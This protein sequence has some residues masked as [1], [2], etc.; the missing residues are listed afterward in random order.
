[1]TTRETNLGAA[2][3]IVQALL[4]FTD[5]AV[6]NRPGFIVPDTSS[7]LGV[8]WSAASHRM[9]GPEK[10]DFVVY[11]DRKGKGKSKGRRTRLG[12]K[13]PNSD[14][15]LENGREVGRYRPAGL[16]PEAA[17]WIYQQIANIWSCDNEFAARWASFAFGE[18]H[19]DLK[20]ALAAFMLVQ[21]RSGMPVTEGGEFLFND[22]DYR[23]VGEAMLLIRRGD[24]KGFNPKLILR[25]RELLKLPGVAAI[26]RGLGF[27]RSL[28]NEPVGR[29]SRTVYKWLSH[30]EQ[31]PRLLSK[32]VNN[33]FKGS[34]RK[35]AKR[36]GYKP[37]SA[38]FFEA[39]GWKQEQAEDGR[40]TIAIGQEI[41]GAES[42]EGLSEVEVCKRITRT[43]PNWKR[44]VGLLNR[45]TITPAMV[46]AG[47][48]AGA[49]SSKDML[50]MTGT[51]EELGL[52]D[53]QEVRAKWERATQ[54]ATDL[55]ARNVAQKV[56]SKEIKEKLEDAADNALKKSIADVVRGMRVYVL[57][58]IS[59][60]MN[61]GI[62]V[63][64]T[65]LA[66]MLQ[67]F[68]L[69]K[70]HV[71]VFNNSGRVVTI[72]HASAKGV[73]KAFEGIRATGGTTHAAGVRALRDFKPKA[74]ED[75]LF[76]VVGDEGEDGN[77]AAE[78][79]ASGLRPM[80]FGLVKLKT[81]DSGKTA[82]TATARELGIPCFPITDKTFEDPYA[83]TRTLRT[84]VSATPVSLKA[85]TAVAPT[86]ISLQEQIM[87]TELLKRPGWA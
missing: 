1:M 77:F 4:T 76:I 69:E 47:I 46:V 25:V 67:G 6:H 85:A 23:E 15:I 38:Q 42:W 3:Q 36:A 26:N 41:K 53:I 8:R 18:D 33:G 32:L 66:K 82:V 64:K 16:F 43:K 30:Y 58:D 35:M 29:W 19:R 49:F 12:I 24:G 56:R 78:V 70:L 63:A 14:V 10:A 75:T 7:V 61:M 50:L 52:L 40:R 20:V 83:I 2:E 54:E 48:D 34:I 44:L 17:T 80:A 79:K 73:Q 28:R 74:D 57:V 72:P 5:H 68:P 59:M 9:E 13:Q 11:V 65:Y 51:L 39:L 60:S 71:A 45:V 21:S 55:R 86:R 22:E 37:A 81:A 27:G 31:N 87:K 62:E 84:L